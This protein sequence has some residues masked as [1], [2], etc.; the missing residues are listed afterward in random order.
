MTIDNVNTVGGLGPIQVTST[1]TGGAVSITM[2]RCTATGA[3]GNSATAGSEATADFVMSSAA[4]VVSVYNNTFTAAGASN[5]PQVKLTNF[6]TYFCVF[7]LSLVNAYFYNNVR[8][9][10]G[11][12]LTSSSTVAGSSIDITDIKFYHAATLPSGSVAYVTAG[13]SST[14]TINIHDIEVNLGLATIVVFATSS[15]SMYIIC[16]N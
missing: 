7:P 13:V 3:L 9:Y 1:A 8:D 16:T 6:R 2:T 12:M 10:G 11:A 4:A 5:A 14:G 15:G